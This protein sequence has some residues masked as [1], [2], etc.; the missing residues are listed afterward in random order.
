MTI[1]RKSDK[2]AICV[3]P[4]RSSAIVASKKISPDRIKTRPAAADLM[5]VD[6][7]GQSKEAVPS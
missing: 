5:S 1:P 4:E 6:V 7:G 3:S 2:F